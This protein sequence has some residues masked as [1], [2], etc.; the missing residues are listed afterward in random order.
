MLLY[1]ISPTRQ[2]PEPTNLLQ[3]LRSP[4]ILLNSANG[5]SVKTF[6]SWCMT[7]HWAI[8]NPL[9][10]NEDKILT[11]VPSTSVKYMEDMG[12]SFQDVSIFTVSII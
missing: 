2:A 5:T 10:A 4:P 6:L 12:F 3:S 8:L 9:S 11:T 7:L 1:R